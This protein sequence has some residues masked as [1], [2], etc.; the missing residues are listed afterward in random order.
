MITYYLRNNFDLGKLAH[1]LLQWFLLQL[2]YGEAQS[3]LAGLVSVQ[4]QAVHKCSKLGPFLQYTEQESSHML[5]SVIHV[6]NSMKNTWRSCCVYLR[7]S[8]AWFH[9]FHLRKLSRRLKMENTFTSI[10]SWGEILKNFFKVSFLG[11][12]QWNITL[13]PQCSPLN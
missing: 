10:I 11:K 1:N 5:T 2:Q 13:S 8:K 12:R 7:A 9:W 6:C 3:H 4:C